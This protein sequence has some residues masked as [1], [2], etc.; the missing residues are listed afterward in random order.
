[1]KVYNPSAAAMHFVLVT[2][3]ANL[4]FGELTSMTQITGLA[5]ILAGL[6]FLMMS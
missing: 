5:L 6:V 2:L 4:Y 3:V 1:M